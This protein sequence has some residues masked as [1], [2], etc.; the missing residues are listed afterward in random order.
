MKTMAV[1]ELKRHFSEVLAD[2][3]RRDKRDRT[4]QISPL[5]KAADAITIDTT[6]LSLE[7]QIMRIVSEIRERQG[8]GLV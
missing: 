1:G 7:E 4:R 2:I 6:S 8:E 3:K 5:R